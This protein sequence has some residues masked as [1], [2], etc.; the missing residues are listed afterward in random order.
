MNLKA[1]I[2]LIA[3]HVAADIN[4]GAL[5]A[6]LPFIKD[7]LNLSYTMTATIILVYNVT[8]SVIQ[9]IFGFLS[10]RWPAKWMLP[11]GCFLA[12]LGMAIVGLSP[13]YAYVLFFAA[14]SGLGQAGYHPE[15][16]KAVNLLAGGKKASAN[17]MFLVG[18]NLG[19]TLGPVM[20]TFLY[21]NF[22]LKGSAGFLL[23]GLIM[24]VIFLVTRS[25]WDTKETMPTRRGKGSG[26]PGSFRQGFLPMTL[27]LLVV[28]VRGVTW[29]GLLTFIP[30]YFINVLHADPLIAG[31]YLSAFL[32]AGTLGT[33]MGGP[34][35]DRIGYKKTVFLTLAFALI[36][37]YLFYFTRGAWSFLFFGIAGLFLISS[38]SITMAMGQSFMPHHLGMAS[39]LILGMAMGF[40]GIGTTVLGWVA[41]R[42]GLTVSL[43][44]I[45]ILPLVAFLIILF[46]PYPPKFQTHGSAPS[47][48]TSSNS[49]PALF[50]PKSESS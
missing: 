46:V 8:S 26:E 11:A 42:W 12:S 22:G 27:I 50:P 32:L 18:G 19:L 3:G 1:L 49:N 35:A 33:L 10:D 31:K 28:T 7:L 34:V 24:T 17:A 23:P 5:P 14:L 44:I 16:F 48:T 47:P 39:G 37:L 40:G 41:D 30:F 9:P 4:T 6:Y 20:A 29:L 2:L 45:F 43:N 15:A 36:F 13:S 21:G 25:H 38:S